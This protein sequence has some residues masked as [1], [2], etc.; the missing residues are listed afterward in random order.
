[1]EVVMLRTLVVIVSALVL[2]LAAVACSDG[3]PSSQE[4]ARVVVGAPVGAAAVA[5]SGVPTDPA[6]ETGIAAAELT[7]F[8]GGSQV[9]FDAAGVEVAAEDAVPI[10]LTPGADSVA[11][12][13]FHGVYDFLVVAR[14]GLAPANDLAEG[15]VLDVVVHDDVSVFVPLVS[16]IG[17]AELSAPVMVLPNEV[18]DVFLTVR[19]PNRTDLRV[20]TT[21]FTAD[22]QV[23]GADG[24]VGSSNLGIRVTAVC[25]AITIDADVFRAGDAVASAQANTVIGVDFLCPTSD[26]TVTIDLIPPFVSI[27]S[28]TAGAEVTVGSLVELSGETNDAQTGVASVEVYDGVVLLGTADIAEGVPSTWSFSFTP[29]TVR[30]YAL[31]A[32]ATDGAGNQSQASV[33]LVVTE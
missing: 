10:V 14:D 11:L 8:R 25:E 24:I 7:V 3:P 31:T 16:L 15:S 4:V 12:T 19:P 23:A 20:P 1:L 18:V 21:D 29:D 9:F 32:V 26:A 2:A 22:Y 28:P 17:T 30:A 33:G 6:G 27:E 13:L 5:P